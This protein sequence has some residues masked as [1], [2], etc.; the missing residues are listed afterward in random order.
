MV[1]F[2]RVTQLR[3]DIRHR[4]DDA[5]PAGNKRPLHGPV[6]EGLPGFH[7]ILREQ[8]NRFLLAVDIKAEPIHHSVIV[9]GV[10][11]VQRDTVIGR[12]ERAEGLGIEGNTPR[13]QLAK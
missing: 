4:T 5:I 10:D 12:L 3:K 7:D 8:L 2:H 13:G 11:E 6:Q 9:I 1:R